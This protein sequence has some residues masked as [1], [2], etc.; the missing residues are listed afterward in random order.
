[1]RNI[2]YAFENL[3]SLQDLKPIF[4]CI[5]SG[6]EEICAKL[7]ENGVCPYA[8][9]ISWNSM[10]TE[11]KLSNLM[12]S[13]DKVLMNVDNISSS[14]IICTEYDKDLMCNQNFY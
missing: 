2:Q 4:V 8:I 13:L 11:P 5:M 12:S 14:T 7:R 1:M 10:T 6:G 9:S 3:S